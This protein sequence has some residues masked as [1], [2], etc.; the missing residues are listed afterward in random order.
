[1]LKQ[2]EVVVTVKQQHLT[3]DSFFAGEPPPVHVDP[4][5]TVCL[6]SS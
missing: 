6:G 1:M 3:L 5:E 2:I 4:E